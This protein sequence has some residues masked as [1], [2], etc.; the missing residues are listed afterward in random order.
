MGLLQLAEGARSGAGARAGADVLSASSA[1]NWYLAAVNGH[2]APAKT[3]Q[4]RTAGKGRAILCCCCVPWLISL[5]CQ[6][7]STL[8]SPSQTINN[9]HTPRVAALQSAPWPC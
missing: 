8:P 1:G 2:L 9:H 7:A 5:T 6:P 4:C 3:Q